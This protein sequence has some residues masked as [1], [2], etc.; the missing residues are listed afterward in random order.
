[1]ESRCHRAVLGSNAVRQLTRQRKATKD[2]ETLVGSTLGG[3][4]LTRVIGSG[5]MG[6][7]YLA[8]DK[9]IGQ[10]V[11]IKVVKTE[12]SEYADIMSAGQVAERFKQEARA[13]AS[14]DHLNILPLYRYGEEKTR[15]GMRSYMVMQ[16]RPEGSL[17]AWL[18]RR[19][20]LVSTAKTEG[21][22]SHTTPPGLPTGW[23]LQVNEVA[24]YVRQA[25]SALQYAHDRGFIHRDVKPENF[26]LRFDKNSVD[27]SYKAFLLLS[28]FGLAKFFSN[29]ASNSQILGTPT[30]MAPEQFGGYACPESD[31]YA[32]AVMAYCLLAGQPP[33]SGDPIHLMNQHLT[34]QPP[35]IRIFV[36]SL[37]AK[38]EAVL[39]KALAKT[40]SERYSSI[41]EFADAFVQSM[42]QGQR[43]TNMAQSSRPLFSLPAYVQQ[44]QDPSQ[45][46]AGASSPQQAYNIPGERKA[47]LNNRP[48]GSNLA[49]YDDQT[50]HRPQQVMQG[51]Q[52]LASAP[53]SAEATP[54]RYFSSQQAAIS[55]PEQEAPLY[56]TNGQRKEQ[57]NKNQVEQKSKQEVSR[58]N[59][60][61]WIIGGVAAVSIG[62][63]SAGIYFSKQPSSTQSKARPA[64]STTR[65][66][67]RP[68]T[69]PNIKSIL[70]GHGQAVT[71]LAWSPG[72]S[73]L[74][75]GSL[76]RSVRLWKPGQAE[77]SLIIQ[78]H[79]L[80]VQT[81]AWEPA[82]TQI[83][84]GGRDNSI[85]IYSATDGNLNQTFTS[86]NEVISRVAW[87][88]DGA[89][90]FVSTLGGGLQKITLRD[91]TIEQKGT[92]AAF[93]S[94]AL[95]PDGRYLALG[96]DGGYIAILT[97]PE[98]RRLHV[99][100]IH[101]GSIRTLAWSSD[102]MQLASGGIDKTIQIFDISS[103]QVVHSS[104]YS[105]VVDDIAWRPAGGQGADRLAAALANGEMHTWVPDNDVHAIYKGHTGAVTS[106]SWSAQGLATGS[107]DKT[108]IIWN[109]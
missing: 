98:L 109:I 101:K 34:A 85:Q 100:R 77:A 33:F 28:D 7:V 93:R 9:A 103:Q 105:G 70:R 78:K 36:P 45:K 64:G 94:L 86:Q 35:S 107:S 21:Q 66:N 8:E 99:A 13:V 79:K 3:Y 89:N 19:A 10:Q 41:T 2:V 4:S 38:I 53:S 49:V 26:L 60:T 51:P 52:M 56:N 106:V 104:T 30:Y 55:E 18:R 5:G 12:D 20:G 61:R 67:S 88:R 25:A 84:S 37:S 73:Q 50:I 80:G 75:S 40:P 91:K 54:Q 6:T 58:R 71:S 57:D 68:N 87:S 90:L 46:I 48:D 16:Y 108:I 62:A 22:G 14:L 83:A 27:N 42:D 92:K 15:D 74:A 97:L 95:S 63:G 17:W 82:G 72:G 69:R 76:D 23:P 43:N 65:P 44:Q 59:A 39:D 81:V 47:Q 24:D 11:A 32:L 102:S 1:M 31:Q 29:L 96:A